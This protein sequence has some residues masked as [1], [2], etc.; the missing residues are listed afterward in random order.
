MEAVRGFLSGSRPVL[1]GLT[2]GKKLLLGYGLGLLLLIGLGLA[3][4]QS[5]G[6]YQRATERIINEHMPVVIDVGRVH[7]NILQIRQQAEAYILT[8]NQ[9]YLDGAQARRDETRH[10]LDILRNA[11]LPEE[12]HALTLSLAN[13][14]SSFEKRLDTTFAY[15]QQHQD[16]IIGAL[17]QMRVTDT[18]L[19]GTL[20]TEVERFYKLKTTETELLSRQAAEQAVS[21]RLLSIVLAVVVGALFAGVAY[22]LSRGITRSIADLTT[23]AR[24]VSGGNLD[25]V[26]HVSSR[27][28]TMVLAQAFQHMLDRLRG[29]IQQEKEERLALQTTIDGYLT[30]MA[31]VAEGNLSARVAIDARG[32]PEGD[33]LVFLGKNLNATIASLQEMTRQISDTATE[34]SAAAG[35]ILAATTQQASSTAEEA[36]AVTQAT[37]TIEEVHRI[38]AQ[39][40]RQAQDMAD[41][42]RRVIGVSQGGQKA[43]VEAIA[44][45]HEVAERVEAIAQTV[46]SLAQHAQTIGTINAA[47]A[48]IA[49]Q[50]NILALN[51]AVEAARAGAAG[52]G[53][54]VVAQEV[55]NL[56]GQSQN[57]TQQV[58]VLLGDIQRGVAAAV[59]ATEEGRARAGRSL[60]LAAQA[61]E[62]MR[63]LAEK[64]DESGQASGQIAAAAG[65]QMVGVEQIALAMR[66]IQEAANQSVAGMRQIEGE[67]RKLNELAGRLREAV[68]RY[69]L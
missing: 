67:A 16:D 7:R 19:E 11:P 65:Q 13:G 26:V 29:M 1:P 12:Q 45:V 41:L 66:S 69:R 55:R 8:N 27:D 30:H 56:A 5:L 28:E 40:A 53:F 63:L 48:E 49:A 18:Y 20:L 34:L 68:A 15:F 42:A 33:P 51:A 57:A 60:E 14:F 37:A 31:A 35:E 47:V 32:R 43:V 10:L 61:R 38:A 44:G 17:T 50:S 4:L 9:D 54:A 62:A 36:S 24:Q 58:R 3:G 23:A 6:T 64:T 22:I 2:I 46:Q 52:K 59:I 39:T 25:T 21:T